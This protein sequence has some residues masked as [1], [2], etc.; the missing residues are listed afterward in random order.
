VSDIGNIPATSEITPERVYLQRREFIK[1]SLLFAATSSGVGS[2]LL[3]LM[4]GL[5]AKDHEKTANV[6]ATGAPDDTALTIARHY[7][8]GS[9]EKNTSYNGVTNYNNFY[10]FG[11]DKSDPAANAYTLKPR[12][13]HV[14]IDGEVAHPQVSRL[15]SSSNRSPSRN[16]STGCDASKPGR[17]LSHGWV[18]R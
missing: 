7:D 6:A 15:T 12:P 13:W 18:S 9:G 11:T 17:W 8:Y 14:A 5:R 10:E 16:A 1:S 3:W 2:T 4:R